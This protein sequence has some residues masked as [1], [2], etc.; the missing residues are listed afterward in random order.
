MEYQNAPIES[1]AELDQHIALIDDKVDWPSL[2]ANIKTD[3]LAGSEMLSYSS[4][5]DT[6]RLPQSGI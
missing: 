2:E 1:E 4:S 5:F 6:L 3:Y